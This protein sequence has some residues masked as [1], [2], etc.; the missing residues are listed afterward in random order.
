[1][2]SLL[3][4]ALSIAIPLLINE[5]TSN[6]ALGEFWLPP[7]S[8]TGESSRALMLDFLLDTALASGMGVMALYFFGLGFQRKHRSGITSFA[9]YC[10]FAALYEGVSSRIIRYSLLPHLEEAEAGRLQSS[11]F[12]LCLFFLYRWIVSAFNVTVPRVFKY[13]MNALAAGLL[14]LTLNTSFSFWN[15]AIVVFGV[16]SAGIVVF[17]T[18]TVLKDRKESPEGSYYLYTA[19]ISVVAFFGMKFYEHMATGESFFPIPVYHP[20]F[21]L[22]LALYMSEQYEKSVRTVEKLNERLAEI[23]QLKDYFLT[24]TSQ[25][26]KT[27]VNGIIHIS[28]SLLEDERRVLEPEVKEDLELISRIGRRVSILIYD[29]ID[30]SR[31]KLTEQ[32]LD[33]RCVDVHAVVVSVIEIFT[34]LVKG[35]PIDLINRIPREG[36]V[37][38]ADENRL[39]Q[40]LTHLMDNAIKYTLE[41]SISLSAITE[42]DHVVIMVNDTGIGMNPNKKKRLFESYGKDCGDKGDKGDK[43]GAG[44]GLSVVKQLVELQGGELHVNSEPGRGSCFAFSLPRGKQKEHSAPYVPVW[45]SG[46]GPLSDEESCLPET[47]RGGGEFSVLVVD[48]NYSDLKSLANIL[49]VQKYNV[50]SAMDPYSAL[51]WIENRREFDLVIIDAMMPKMSGYEMVRLIREILSPLELPVLLLTAATRPEDVEAAFIAGANDFIEKPY[52]ADALRCRVRTL[53]EL[54]KSKRLLLEKETAFLHAQIKP[55]FLFNAL[56]TIHAC[57]Y[58]SPDK[59]GELLGQ[60]GVFL[61]SSFDFTGRSSFI[62][63]EQELRIVKAY[64]AIEKARYGEAL[65]VEYSFPS[66]ILEWGILPFTIQPIVENAIRHGLFKRKESGKI[67]VVLEMENTKIHVRVTDNGVGMPEAV[68]GELLRPKPGRRGVGLSNINRRLGS[69]YGEALGITSAVNEGTTV[70]FKLPVRAPA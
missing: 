25:E 29:L 62:P 39:K 54:K 51:E 8:E 56:N 46:S 12:V 17:M 24:R 42:K 3:L 66:D 61:R 14:I 27:P 33:F 37:C 43:G 50:T 5:K 55:H 10:L 36:F 26:L 57:C 21:V 23:N 60:L 4:M 44:L 6:R 7:D 49:A 11:F 68:V 48:D 52:E 13:G 64:V 59:A 67:W 22:S 40:I 63:I 58:E 16:V 30:F 38:Y 28:R 31:L 41:G 70:S 18:F 45:K 53:V 2:L 19:V 1:M 69:F 9:E 35:R 65:E 34:P 47:I 15:Y 32:P 20:I